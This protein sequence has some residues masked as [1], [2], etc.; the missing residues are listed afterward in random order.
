VRERV[1]RE[2]LTPRGKTV[3]STGVELVAKNRVDVTKDDAPTVL[4]LLDAL[5]E[6]E[7]VTHVYS[8]AEIPDAVLEALA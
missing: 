4:R 8:N 2:L 5:E 3:E 6:H 7:D 1:E